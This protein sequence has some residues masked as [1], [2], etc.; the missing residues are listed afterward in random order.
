V[1]AKLL[2]KATHVDVRVGIFLKETH[3]NGIVSMKILDIH[4]IH[5]VS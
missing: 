3:V 4:P 1:S 5:L 2:S